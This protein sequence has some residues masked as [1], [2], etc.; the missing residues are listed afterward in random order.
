MKNLMKENAK[1]TMSYE[2][3]AM[4]YINQD[5]TDTVP[6]GFGAASRLK[7]TPSL[8][9]TSSFQNLSLEKEAEEQCRH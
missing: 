1:K 4:N 2:P 3:R 8:Y 5:S 7:W 9:P 6:I